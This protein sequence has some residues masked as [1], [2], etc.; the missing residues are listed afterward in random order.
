[1]MSPFEKKIKEENENKKGRSKKKVANLNGILEHYQH[2]HDN[3][4][5]IGIV[6]PTLAR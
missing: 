3:R 2:R 5:N 1:M 4:V 6:S